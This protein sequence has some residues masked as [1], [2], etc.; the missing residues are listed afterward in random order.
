[1]IHHHVALKFAG[2]NANVRDAVAM[3]RIHVRLDFENE[4]G[5][6]LVAWLDE[7]TGGRTAL[8]RRRVVQKSLEDQLNTKIVH[9]APEEHRGRASGENLVAV[10][11]RAGDVEHLKFLG[12]LEHEFLLP[13][14]AQ[15]DRKSR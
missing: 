7:F 14:W 15:Q 4:A 8:R 3:L 11:L 10:K 5:K 13:L 9:R 2:A 12:D 1:M 6:L